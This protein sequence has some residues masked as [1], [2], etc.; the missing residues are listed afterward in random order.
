MTLG[1][2]VVEEVDGSLEIICFECDQI[3]GLKSG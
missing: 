1:V 2:A 3:L